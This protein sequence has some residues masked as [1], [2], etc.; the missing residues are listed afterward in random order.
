[1]RKLVVVLPILVG[2]LLSA[3]S[4][5]RHHDYYD[6][7]YYDDGYYYH[8]D[9]YDDAYYHHNVYN[10]IRDGR[11]YPASHDGLS[12]CEYESY[13]NFTDW[14]VLYYDCTNALYD[15]GSY[16]YHNGWISIHYDNGD[17]VEFFVNKADHNELI[18]RLHN[19]I[20]YH[21]V[22]G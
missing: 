15:K 22:R 13:I 3:N 6:D 21:Y 16:Q 1:M 9:Y 11:W 2:F 5:R 17:Y 20:E 12:R 4:C 18:L 14:E 19:G 7:Y 8:H 10:Y